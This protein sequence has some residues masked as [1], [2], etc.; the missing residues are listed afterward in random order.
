MTD[1]DLNRWVAIQV[2]DIAPELA[3]A[4]ALGQRPYATTATCDYEVLQMAR[5]WIYSKRR[6][7]A[8]ALADLWHSRV[9]LADGLC[10]AFPEAAMRYEPGDYSRAAYAALEAKP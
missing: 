2:F 3:D 4:M 5:L 1:T 10:E 7:F 8:K 9:P 6:A